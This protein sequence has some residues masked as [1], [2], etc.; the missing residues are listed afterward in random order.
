MAMRD[1]FT[2]LPSTL[3]SPV[4]KEGAW[5][6]SDIVEPAI[7]TV[8]QDPHEQESPKPAGRTWLTSTLIN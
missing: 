6:F 5:A 7:M 2:W 8:L 1:D 4:Y 3:N